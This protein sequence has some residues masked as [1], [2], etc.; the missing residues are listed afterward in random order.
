M[1]LAEEYM[2]SNPLIYYSQQCLSNSPATPGLLIMITL[3][4]AN[5]GT[6]CSFPKLA[7]N[8]PKTHGDPP[9]CFF[10]FLVYKAYFSYYAL[11]L[12]RPAL[13]GANLDHATPVQLW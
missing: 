8:H 12:N 3:W 10:H 1:I 13:L 2:S 11:A 9:S 6:L 5:K 4:F 7:S